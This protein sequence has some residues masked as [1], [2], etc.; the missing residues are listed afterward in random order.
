MKLADQFRTLFKYDNIEWCVIIKS[1]NLL[2]KS[3]RYMKT[4]LKDI[5]KILPRLVRP[6]PFVGS[7]DLI[8]IPPPEKLMSILPSA[9]YF[10]K[11]K[12]TDAKVKQLDVLVNIDF[13]KLH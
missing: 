2:A 6:C 3:N 12:I 13:V 9:E 4:I 1:A 8:E 11:I 7:L 10:V 5:K